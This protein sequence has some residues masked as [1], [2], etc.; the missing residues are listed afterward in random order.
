MVFMAVFRMVMLSFWILVSIWVVY[1]VM[2]LGLRVK[3]A[4][5]LSLRAKRG[6]G[7]I[8]LCRGRLFRR[9]VFDLVLGLFR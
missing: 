4:V 5:R 2:G 3:Q 6:W 7:V 1:L 8:L 9:I